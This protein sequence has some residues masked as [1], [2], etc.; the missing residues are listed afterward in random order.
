MIGFDHDEHDAQVERSSNGT[1]HAAVLGR[2]QFPHQQERD[3]PKADREADHEHNQTN[4]RQEPEGG[5]LSL[6]RLQ[7]DF[8]RFAYPNSWFP[9]LFK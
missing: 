2:E 3:A 1:E 4:Q 7:L 5:R 8:E 9:W 6:S